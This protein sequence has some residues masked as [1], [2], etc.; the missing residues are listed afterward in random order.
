MKNQLNLI[1]LVACL[2]VFSPVLNAQLYKVELD[3]KVKSAMLIAE[4]KVIEKKS[5]WNA[6]HTM[7]YTANTVEVY[8]LFKGNL[9]EKNIEIITEGGG[10]DNYFIEASD[11]LNLDKGQ[12]GVFFCYQR[13]SRPLSPFTRKQLYDVYSSDQG[14]LRY[15]LGNDLAYTPFASYNGIEKNLYPLIQAKTGELIK[16]VN[17]AFSVSAASEA[18]AGALAATISSF[19]PASVNAGAI[20]DPGNN[21]LTING[22]GFGAVPSGSCAVKFKDGNSASTLPDYSVV[23][24]SP[25]IISWSDT[26]I[27]IKVPTR[28]ATGKIAVVNSTG[29][30]TSSSSVLNVV[31]SVF[32][33]DFNLGGVITPTEARLM[34]TNVSGGYSLLYCTNTAGNGVDLNSAPEKETFQRALTTWK[35]TVGINFSEAGTTT[36]QTVNPNDA[37]N[38]IMFDNTNKGST[39]GSP[40][41]AGVLATTYSGFSTCG[42]GFSGQKTGFDMVIRN[43]KVSLGS[44]TFTVGPCFP[45]NNDIDLEMVILHELGHAVDLAHINDSYEGSFI[46]N[47]NPSKLMHYAVVNYVDRRSLD[48]S[49]FTG[50]RYC[51][52]MENNN[53]GNCIGGYTLEMLPL[54]AIVASNDE[55]PS[56]FPTTATPNGAIVTFD[57]AHATSNKNGDPK[58]NDVNCASTITNVTNNAYYAIKTNTVDGG[59]LKITISDYTT[60]PSTQI[61][62]TDQAVRFALY[63]V[64]ACPAGQA[65]PAPIKCATFSAAGPLADITNLKANTTYLLYFDGVRNTKATF[66]A[67][68]NGT[69]LPVTLSKFY[70]EYIKG[71]NKLYIDIEQAINVKSITVEKSATG[72]NFSAIGNLA[73]NASDLVGTHIYNDAQPFAG[74]NYYRLAIRDN[75]GGTQYSNIILLKNDAGRLAYIYPNPVRDL[76][77]I[78]IT[79]KD[80]G[81]YNCNVYDI[82]GKLVST[83]VINVVEGSQSVSLPFS[84]FGSGA[85]IVKIT[86][87]N[88]EVIL[89]QKLIK[90]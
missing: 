63:E 87:A 18:G 45:A 16:T 15:D 55:C 86:D 28:A 40:L 6:E 79:S 64:S 37:N 20:N 14:F 4:G 42:A 90:Q 65:F 84:N 10:V 34:N 44:T 29:S 73:F 51:A 59:T 78:S 56:S 43:N 82:S 23:Y 69:A 77:N 9:I 81:R 68:F 46:P 3:E 36:V 75:D 53:Y 1:A 47:L 8:K 48:Y 38:I 72:N 83:R 13:A 11:L 80:A 5:F 33:V 74:N 21:T 17:S 50:G 54:S 25:Y 41:A 27:Q 61:S 30:S 35:E 22:T 19:S 89:R 2:F 39:Y 52:K 26:K 12:T 57:L 49:A 88:R 71:M 58:S 70:G 62:C 66:K 7:I 85:Y 60:T 76:L 67:T 32:C 24:S 31:Y